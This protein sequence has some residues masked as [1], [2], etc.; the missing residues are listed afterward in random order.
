MRMNK[1]LPKTAD[2]FIQSKKPRSSHLNKFHKPSKPALLA[3]LF[4]TIIYI[5]LGLFSLITSEHTSFH[6]AS[7]VKQAENAPT[8]GWDPNQSSPSSDFTGISPE[9]SVAIPSPLPSQAQ[10]TSNNVPSITPIPSIPQSGGQDISGI[11]A[12]II[13]TQQQIAT[14]MQTCVTNAQQMA[15]QIIAL[16]NQQQQIQSQR[17]ALNNQS[18]NINSS[19]PEGQRQQEAINAQMDNLNQQMDNVG[20]A[21][22]T[23]QSNASTANG[24]CSNTVSQLEQQRSNQE[25]DLDNAFSNAMDIQMP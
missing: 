25:G 1:P 19:T 2:I 9:P 12:Q 14:Q 20:N 11:S 10:V 24:N 23:A 13:S 18:S 6:A 4:L 7:M 15:N 22:D 3:T 5:L 17:D 8:S 16:K 21:I